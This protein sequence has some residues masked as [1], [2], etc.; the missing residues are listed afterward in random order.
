MNIK[1]NIQTVNIESDGLIFKFLP[2]GDINQIKFN[3]NNVSMYKATTLD[4]TLGNIYLKTE[5][6]HIQN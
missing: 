1:N 6:Y 4:G 3:N 5:L 2:S